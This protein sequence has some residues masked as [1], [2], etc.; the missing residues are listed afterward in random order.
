MGP[1]EPRRA[2]PAHELC[3]VVQGI[4]PRFEDAEVVCALGTRNLFY[5]RLPEVKCTAGTAALM[6]DEVYRRKAGWERTLS[7][8]LPR[9]DPLPH[10]TLQPLVADGSPL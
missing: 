4:A 5:A 9:A 3:L 7:Q 8:A 2:F 1:W 6:M 10:V